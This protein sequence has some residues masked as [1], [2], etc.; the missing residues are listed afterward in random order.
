M[1]ESKSRV[2]GNVVS[3][4]HKA[5]AG[6]VNDMLARYRDSE[7]LIR[8]G[9]YKKGNDP[10]TD[11]AIDKNAAINN[12][13]KQKMSEKSSFDDALQGIKKLAGL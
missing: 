13:L 1:L 3:E 12:F 2:M 6:K 10:A 5:A 11:E 7:L 8:I 9:E 4:E